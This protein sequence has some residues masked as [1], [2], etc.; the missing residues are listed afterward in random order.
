[1]VQDKRVRP[2][3]C[4][5]HHHVHRSVHDSKQGAYESLPRALVPTRQATRNTR[6]LSGVFDDRCGRQLV[7]LFHLDHYKEYCVY[8]KAIFGAA[9][10]LKRLPLT[11]DEGL[12]MLIQVV[13]E[14]SASFPKI[15]VS[16]FCCSFVQWWRKNGMWSMGRGRVER[17]GLVRC[18]YHARDNRNHPKK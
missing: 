8:F 16:T 18:P 12:R 7:A 9:A 13:C 5:N 17:N 6:G 11:I 3:V 14:N 15:S 4:H 10:S 2:I 1:M